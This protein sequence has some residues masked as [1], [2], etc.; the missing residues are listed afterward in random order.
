MEPGVQRR[1]LREDTPATL[2]LLPPVGTLAATKS[3]ESGHSRVGHEPVQAAGAESPSEVLY[4]VF[5]IL[6]PVLD[7]PHL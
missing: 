2:F 5:R 7:V 3:S 4:S 6:Y 1:V